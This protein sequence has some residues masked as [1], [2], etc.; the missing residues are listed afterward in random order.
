LLILVNAREG[1]NAS[2]LVKDTL[3]LQQSLNSFDP[4][5]L[6]TEDINRVAEIVGSPTF[7]I[8]GIRAECEAAVKLA[9]WVLD[10]VY[11]TEIFSEVTFRT[12][13]DIP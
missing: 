5:D 4:A 13:L 8:E 7:T 6:T 10:I 1:T 9:Q 3:K 11:S 2:D 12:P